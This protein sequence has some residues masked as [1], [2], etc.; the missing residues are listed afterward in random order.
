MVFG[1]SFKEKTAEAIQRGTKAALSGGFFHHTQAQKFN[2]NDEA[3][4]WLYTQALVHQIY[5]LGVLYK[6]STMGKYKWATPD[7]L[8]K[9]ID[10]ALTEHEIIEGLTPGTRRS[11]IFKRCI[12]MDNLT[13][14]ER[15]TGQHYHHSAKLV[16]EKDSNANEASIARTLEGVVD[17]YFQQARKMFGV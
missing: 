15:E 10:S 1:L 9:N 7:F 16:A 6:H 11:F 8:T 17:S 13:P 14:K 5:M 12:E 3:T 2:L 4:A